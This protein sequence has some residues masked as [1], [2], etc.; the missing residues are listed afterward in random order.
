MPQ[1]PQ[2][3]VEMIEI[4]REIYDKIL[5]ELKQR[6]YILADTRVRWISLFDHSILTAGIAVAA[7]KELLIRGK[8]TEDICGKNLTTEELISV[9]RIS[10]L[11]H[12][13]GKY[14]EEAYKNHIER[15]VQ[16]SK[17]WLEKHGIRQPYIDLILSAIE[18][19]QMDYNPKTLHEKI[20][21]LAD[22]LASAG[23]RPELAK[24]HTRDELLN[25]S[26]SIRELYDIVFDAGR[27]LA[28]ILG[29]VDQVKS[30]VYETTRLPE[31]RGASEILNELNDKKLVEIFE[32]N[33]SKECLIYNGGGSFL[34]VASSSIAEDL[35]NDIQ[36]SYLTYT[37]TATISCVS[38]PV[39]YLEFSR[40]LMPYADESIQELNGIGIGKWLLESHFGQDRNKWIERKNFGEFVSNLSVELVRKKDR[41]ECIPFFEALPVGKRCQSCGKRVA[42]EKDKISPDEPE[43]FICEICKVKRD[44]GKG[45]KLRFLE[46]FY[47]WIK[48]NKKLDLN[49]KKIP[50]HLD[51][52]VLSDGNMAFI[53][54]D[55]NDIGS[56]LAKAKSPAHYRHIADAFS[57]GVKDSLYAA[58]FETLGEKKLRKFEKLPF[59]IIYVGGDDASL[60]MAAPFAFDFSVNFLD[61][62]ENNPHLVKLERELGFA[63]E[64]KITIS[65]GIL[66]CK[67]TYPIYFAEKI[68]EDLLKEA[69]KRSKEVK[70]KTKKSESTISYLYL[71]SPT[72]TESADE[73]IEMIY[74]NEKRVLTLRPYTK[75]EIKFLLNKSKR[76]RELF[77][78]SQREALM[79]A[80]SKGKFQSINFL[81]YQIARMKEEKRKEAQEILSEINSKFGAEGGWTKTTNRK[82]ATPLVDLLEIIKI[83]SD[84]NG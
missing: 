56:I 32:R 13:W 1:K 37:K 61:Q 62:F 51:E 60:I 35:S 45:E 5:K 15:S 18:R 58:L 8:K 52:L 10:S 21:C 73:I 46:E 63:E 40:G 31:I 36:R 74:K 12:D 75:S 42:T 81:F 7:T 4:I 43:E 14:H 71:T 76:I 30:Y 6:D 44:R 77:P 41:K 78:A 54:A 3:T 17:E 67:S 34:A 65:L 48:D 70:V 49:F 29:D 59:E 16:W 23:D 47:E 19:H 24:A 82:N 33:L 26:R 11:L 27:G 84:I 53:Y 68:A 55:G 69:K 38:H 66:I 25:I 50:K 64:E 28:I 2:K 39:G 20:L 72:A 57:T 80:L 22:S 9:I 79:K 83:K